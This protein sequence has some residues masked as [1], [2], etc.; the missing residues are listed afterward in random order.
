M[1]HTS[2]VTSQ[3]HLRALSSTDSV[4]Q[5]LGQGPPSTICSSKSLLSAALGFQCHIATQKLGSPLSGY[6]AER[7]NGVKDREKEGFISCRK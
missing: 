2:L 3:L 1:N 7:H 4:A 6:R 5:V